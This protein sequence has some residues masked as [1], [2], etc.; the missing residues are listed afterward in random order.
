MADARETMVEGAAKVVRWV[1]LIA[2]VI[3]VT[4]VLLTVGEAN[5]A[6]AIT[7]FFA[8]WA[9]LVVFWFRDLFT[10]ADA[11]LQVLVNYGLAAVAWLAW[12]LVSR[13]KLWGSIQQIRERR[14][15]AAT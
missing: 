12:S 2:A 1:G 4:H 10:P 8:D 5:P 9:D 7:G 11:R 14:R 6:N 15:K 13:V 3:L